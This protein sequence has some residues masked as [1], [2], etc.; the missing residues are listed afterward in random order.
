MGIESV[1][2]RKSLKDNRHDAWRNKSRD[3]RS[4]Q[5]LIGGGISDGSHRNSRTKGMVSFRMNG[6]DA[7]EPVILRSRKSPL[8]KEA[9]REIE[10]AYCRADPIT[11]KYRPN[12]TVL[13]FISQRG[14]IRQRVIGHFISEHFRVEFSKFLGDERQSHFLY[15]LRNSEYSTLKCSEINWPMTR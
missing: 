9:P 15:P 6:I 14:F 5:K 3:F 13:G 10:F 2:T 1:S 4:V 11:L 12:R 8:S 7:D